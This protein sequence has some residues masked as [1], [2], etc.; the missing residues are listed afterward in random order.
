MA[1]CC[2]CHGPLVK[3]QGAWWCRD[4]EADRE[5]QVTHASFTGSGKTLQFLYVPTPVQTV[6]H[7]AVY[8]PEVT[9]LLVGGQAGPGKSR[10]LRETL[11]E[12][13]R[14]IPGFH[15]LLLR[16]THKDLD[17]SHLRFVPYEVEQ[18]GGKWFK[19]DKVIEFPHPGQPAS[20]I[21]AGHMEDSGAIENYLSAEYDAIAPD[22]LVTFERDAM[23]ELFTRAR[24]TNTHLAEIRGNTAEALDG[25]LVMTATNPGGRGALWVKEFFIDQNPDPEEFPAYDPRRWRFYGARLDDN[26]YM[27]PGYKEALMGLRET[28]RRQLLEGDWNVFEGAFFSE[29][30]AERHGKPWHVR[31]LAF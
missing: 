26:P 25:S 6:W 30:R 21:R 27:A 7:E 5:R 12:L 13:A 2:W 8:D 9:R 19:G 16:K 28:R 15:G 11:Y 10:W 1:T 4:T 3:S 14:V 18:R 20:V 31:E 29:F 22:E 17:Q 24:S 23:L